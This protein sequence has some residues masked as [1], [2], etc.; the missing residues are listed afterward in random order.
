M[1]VFTTFFILCLGLSIGF[2]MILG[3]SSR[4]DVMA[5]WTERR[6]DFD[7]IL[8]AH[9]YKPSNDNRSIFEFSAD[10]LKFC[11][12]DK[13]KTYLLTLFGAMYEVMKKQMAATGV[14][15]DVMQALRGQL[16]NIYDPFS[17]LMNRFFN[18]FRQAG[19]L[20]SRIFQH[21]YMSMK[22]TAAIALATLFRVLSLQA[23]L[24][25]TVDLVIKVILIFLYILI[26]S[27]I[28]I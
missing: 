12:S 27:L 24:L 25:N 17:K 4:D 22:K 19:F 7:V 3:K 14:L 8:A 5:H 26:L 23:A 28:H 9:T 13:T 11:V 2:A 6:C 21:L 18:K 20:A 1:D 10:N 16:F 15:N